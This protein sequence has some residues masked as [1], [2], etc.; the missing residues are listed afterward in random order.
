M[1]H[2]VGA[3][4]AAACAAGMTL[5]VGLAAMPEE[6]QAAF[7][8]R[9]DA[10][11]ELGRS[12]NINIG[13]VASGRAQFS[14]DTIASAESITRIVAILP[15]LFPSGSDVPESHLKPELLANRARADELIATVQADAA[16]LVQAVKTGD[17]EQIAGAYRTLDAACNACH[18]EFRRQ[19]E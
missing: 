10:M 3:F 7:A 19:Y 6:N 1:R 18:D 4:G 5:A 16:A 13:R 2:R 11:K 8:R 15:T 17:R 14:P 9:D 12:F